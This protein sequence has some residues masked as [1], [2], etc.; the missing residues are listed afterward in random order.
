MV[1]G[2]ATNFPSPRR[3]QNFTKSQGIYDD[4]QKRVGFRLPNISSYFL[5]ISSYHII[6]LGWSSWK[7]VEVS[8][9]VYKA[10]GCTRGF[11]VVVRSSKIGR[12]LSTYSFIFVTYFFISSTHFFIFPTY[13][14]IC[15][16][17]AARNF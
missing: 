6:I 3:A 12:G 8:Q 14:Y 11:L 13:V 17:G 2:R 10:W 15:R 16:G 1:K 4:S 5:N 9:S 7:F